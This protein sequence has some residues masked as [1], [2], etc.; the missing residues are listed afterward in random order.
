VKRSSRPT[1]GLRRAAVLIG[2]LLM[3]GAASGAAPVDAP[4]STQI[5]A[6][7]A[8]PPPPGAAAEDAPFDPMEASIL[9]LQAAMG[10]GRTT[11]VALVD[12]YLARIEGLDRSGPKLNAIATVN[13]R[14]RRRAAS[15]DRE[16]AAGRVRG[17]LH[18]IPVVVK[19]NY[20]T[21]GMPT[22]AGSSALEGFAPDRDAFLVRR[23]R[24]AGAIVL[25]KTNMQEFAFGVT[26]VG[27]GFGMV[28]NPYA[29]NR[30]PG[31]SSSGTAAAVA[32]NLAVIGLGTDTC[33]SIRIPAAFNNLVGLRGTQGLTSRRGIVPLSSTQDIGGPLARSV[34][35]LA[36]TLDVIV[37]FDPEDDQ[38]ADGYGR[39]GGASYAAG[40]NATALQGARI[41]VLEE[42]LLVDPQDR[43]VANVVGF[44]V[45]DMR[46]LGA[47]IVRVSVPG[48]WQAFESRMNGFFVLVYEFKRDLN[49]YLRDNPD[50]PVRSLADIIATG[51][52]HADVEDSLRA[53]Q[54]M[55]PASRRDYLEAL[56][57][58]DA[59]R[60]LLLATM[61][62]E[63]LDVLIYPTVRRTAAPL[64][65]PQPG[66][67]CLLAANTG[68]PA[69]S[70]PAGFTSQ[71][72]PVGLEMLG[73]PWSEQRLLALAYAYEQGAGKR[74]PPNLPV[75]VP[76]GVD[77][78]RD[79]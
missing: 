61:A 28:R 10:S 23:L 54:A 48:L 62:R 22:T 75:V 14:A 58:R 74:Q 49:A 6:L 40:L 12:Y 30:N 65:A 4:I 38:T 3:S 69:L 29:P 59:L 31:G 36:L 18:G 39:M 34:M 51:S 33:G 27:S 68:L 24:K 42:A 56:A 35:D 70:V 64:G 21:R 8:A 41:G 25:A 16:R 53:S 60:R 79:R 77:A 76:T 71:G 52:Y 17:P 47:T 43:S 5:P 2:L 63:R 50:A 66:S 9:G 26:S 46:A 67:N 78:G 15:L 32:A 55:G 13:E 44:A 72:V 20:E 45:D 19:D 37:G 57:Q 73:V 1:A 11:A 7:M